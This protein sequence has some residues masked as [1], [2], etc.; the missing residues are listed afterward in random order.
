M[1]GSLWFSRSLSRIISWTTAPRENL[2]SLQAKVFLQGQSVKSPSI[3]EFHSWYLFGRRELDK[4]VP[5]CAQEL[6]GLLGRENLW[7][8]VCGS[9][10][11]TTV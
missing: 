11:Y 6:S 8:L 5:S 3:T 4:P 9:H 1:I 10:K 7:T 2:S